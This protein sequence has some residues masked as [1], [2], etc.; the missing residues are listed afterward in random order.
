MG[1]DLQRLRKDAGYKSARDFA[2]AHGFTYSTYAR[3][4]ADPSIIP[5][6]SAWRIADALGCSIDDIVGRESPAD[7]RG[8][9]QARFDAL[10]AEGKL[11]VSQIVEFAEGKKVE[12]DEAERHERDEG[13][14]WR[15][16]RCMRRMGIEDAKREEIFGK[17]CEASEDDPESPGQKRGRFERYVIDDIVDR[18]LSRREGVDE[19]EGVMRFYDAW[20]AGEIQLSSDSG[21]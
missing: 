4:E 9:V 21:S 3:Y 10:D 15:F 5:T 2:D 14:R 18:G 16:E 1:K 11:L 13:Y 19:L 12:R 8:A 17:R 7:P 20:T 6:K